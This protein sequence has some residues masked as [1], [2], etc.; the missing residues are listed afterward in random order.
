MANLTTGTCKK[1][2]KENIKYEFMFFCK[3]CYDI[4]IQQIKN[5]NLYKLKKNETD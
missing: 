2:K 5:K 1:C 3:E 4:E